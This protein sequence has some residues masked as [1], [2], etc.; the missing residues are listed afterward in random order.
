MWWKK[1]G[2]DAGKRREK[3]ADIHC[4]ILPG[5]DDG[6]GSLEETLR[7]LRMAA[8]EGITDVIA[9]PH[10]KEGR[11]CAGPDQVRET[12]KEI[13]E[14]ANRQQIPVSL[15]FGH[16][17]LYFS[18]LEERLKEKQICT[19]NDTSCVLIEFMPT[20]SFS[21][22][23]NALDQVAGTGY[24]PILAHAER[25]SC[26]LK[27]WKRAGQLHKMGI[28]IQLNASGIVGSM[29]SG[30]RTFTHRMISEHLA[31]YI[32]TDAHD[33]RRRVPAVKQCAAVLERLCSSE[34]ADALLY[35]NAAKILNQT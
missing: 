4:H 12:V 30:I 14:E 27:D 33:S 28:G 13:Q 18:D 17:I 15:Y 3:T 21:Y 24:L 10:Y 9:T 19:L 20:E 2:T 7:M 5:L 32:G 29:G 8:D 25:Y 22:I 1:T 26:L 11:R 35:G 23:R 34:Y 6:A 31:D 16:E